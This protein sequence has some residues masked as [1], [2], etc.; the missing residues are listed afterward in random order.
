[1]S[2]NFWLPVVSSFV[3]QGGLPCGIISVAGDIVVRGFPESDGRCS[4][5][6]AY[7]QPATLVADATVVAGGGDVFRPSGV[8]MRVMPRPVT[9]SRCST[10]V[11]PACFRPPHRPTCGDAAVRAPP[12]SPRAALQVQGFHGGPA[13]VTMW[14]FPSSMIRSLFVGSSSVTPVAVVTAMD[15]GR[16]RGGAPTSGSRYLSS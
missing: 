5:H 13:A 8:V 15:F 2:W 7:F 9:T 4:P 1:M 16:P 12:A 10:R 14:S 3:A 6:P 11:R